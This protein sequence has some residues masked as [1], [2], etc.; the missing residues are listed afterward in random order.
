M[1]Q[2]NAQVQN[3]MKKLLVIVVLGLFCCNFS[4]AS[5]KNIPEINTLIED[6]FVNDSSKICG[7]TQNDIDTSLK[8]I[9]SN[10]K[11]KITDLNKYDIPTL[12]IAGQVNTNGTLCVA[13]I[14]IS[15]YFYPAKDPLKNDNSGE[16]V[17]FRTGSSLASSTSIF[18][19]NY[20]NS[21][22]MLLKRFVVEWAEDNK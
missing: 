8:Y 13:S 9:L 18:K 4:N 15:L 20:I 1:L 2:D 12:Y 16:F 22:E 6:V 19:N 14:S 3:K 21:L 17:Y 10:S 7:L 11:I 5:M